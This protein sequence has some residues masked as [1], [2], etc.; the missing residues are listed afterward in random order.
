MSFLDTVTV[1]TRTGGIRTIPGTMEV[2][3]WSG[4]GTVT[5]R[6]VIAPGC[7]ARLSG[8]WWVIAGVRCLS[9]SVRLVKWVGWHRDGL[10]GLRA[11]LRRWS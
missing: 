2:N 6:A 5:L 3:H 7:T 1:R 9:L 4:S 10:V 8:P 11:R